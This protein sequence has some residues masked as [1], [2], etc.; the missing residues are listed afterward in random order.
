MAEEI[1]KKETIVMTGPEEHDRWHQVIYYILGVVEVLLSLRFAFRLFGANPGSPIVD[2]LYAITSPLIAPFRG[3]FPN[4]AEERYVAEWATLVGMA[5]YAL[6]A[7]GI[8]RLVEI[9]RNK[10][11]S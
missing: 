4:V 5:I 10:E 8:I 11:S 9:A 1:V 2:F 7:I 6:I 3:I